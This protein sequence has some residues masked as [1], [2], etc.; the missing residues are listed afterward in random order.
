MIYLYLAQA[1]TSI[2]ASTTT[3]QAQGSMIAELRAPSAPDF[4]RGWETPITA[5]FNRQSDYR[6]YYVL[7]NRTSYRLFQ[8]KVKISN[9]FM[10]L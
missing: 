6:V 10:A 5:T 7:K 9:I 4:V 1:F 8:S 2:V 3:V